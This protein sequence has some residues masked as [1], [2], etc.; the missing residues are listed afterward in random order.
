MWPV[1]PEGWLPALLAVLSAEVTIWNPPQSHHRFPGAFL[2]M[3]QYLLPSQAPG[4]SDKE[5][6]LSSVPCLLTL[7]GRDKAG[8]QLQMFLC[9]PGQGDPHFFSGSAALPLQLYKE[10]R[11]SENLTEWSILDYHR[12]PMYCSF[13][14]LQNDFFSFFS[15]FQHFLSVNYTLSTTACVISIHTCFLTSSFYYSLNFSTTNEKSWRYYYHCVC[16]NSAW[17]SVKQRRSCLG[18]SLQK[19]MLHGWAHICSV[20]SADS[21]QPNCCKRPHGWSWP[22][23]WTCLPVLR[24]VQPCH[25]G[26]FADTLALVSVLLQEI[27]WLLFTY[28]ELVSF[29]QNDEVSF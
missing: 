12:V 6:V 10:V 15:S 25:H 20:S 28:A 16:E 14:R 26:L 8:V 23:P 9:I 4:S 1:A 21:L 13:F 11:S 22:I 19:G 24:C 29:I 17:D 18:I 5:Q 2:V 3:G 27:H 7:R